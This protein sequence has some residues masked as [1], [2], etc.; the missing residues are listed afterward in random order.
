M[1]C[2]S[3]DDIMSTIKTMPA[4]GASNSMIAG[5]VNRS[6]RTVRYHVR[7]LDTG[8]RTVAAIPGAKHAR[9][10][11]RSHIGRRT[12]EGGGHNLLTLHV[13]LVREHGYNGSLRS[14][15]RYWRKKCGRAQAGSVPQ[16]GVDLTTVGAARTGRQ[17]PAI[18]PARMD[19]SG[20]TGNATT[21]WGAI[22]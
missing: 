9:I 13:F 4:R 5:N 11:R 16:S 17:V 8:R 15:R 22:R 2:V 3:K 12:A 21:R 6:S 19:W 10:R 18:P 7:R 20:E 1:G 14:V